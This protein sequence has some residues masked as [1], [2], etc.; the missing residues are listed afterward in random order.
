MPLHIPTYPDEAF[1]SLPVRPNSNE[2]RVLKAVRDAPGS[3]QDTL[4]ETVP[5]DDSA[6]SGALY[7]LRKKDLIVQADDGTY[8]LASYMVLRLADSLRPL[9]EGIEA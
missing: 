2:G 4:A 7:R 3:D 8:D 1:E 6:L 5:L 9:D